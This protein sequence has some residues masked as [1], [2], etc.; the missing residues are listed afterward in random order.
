MK[1][2]SAQDFLISNVYNLRFLKSATTLFLVVNNIKVTFLLIT[3]GCVSCNQNFAISNSQKIRS[4]L[5][6][7]ENLCRKTFKIQSRSSIENL[8]K[9]RVGCKLNSFH[10]ISYLVQC[11]CNRRSG[12]NQY[13]CVRSQKPTGSAR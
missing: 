10:F 3:K 13:C 4:N 9:A 2:Y 12:R 8:F 7:F 11:N 1:I 6:Y 5:K